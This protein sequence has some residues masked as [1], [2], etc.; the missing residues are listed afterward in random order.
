M[1]LN[2]NVI[3][4]PTCPASDLGGIDLLESTAANLFIAGHV[5]S[6]K[7]TFVRHW[8]A[9]TGETVAVLAPMGIARR[10]RVLAGS[11]RW[12]HPT[13]SATTDRRGVTGPRQHGAGHDDS[14]RA[15]RSGVCKGGSII[16]HDIEFD[17]PFCRTPANA[18]TR[19]A[20][21][22]ASGVEGLSRRLQR[23]TN[24]SG[25]TSCARWG[26]RLKSRRPPGVAD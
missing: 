12:S 20:R 6:G 23:P 22:S 14:A 17:L 8:L 24:S 25:G 9:I 16:D 4:T 18:A 10:F 1:N 19:F 11:A 26:S 21:R 15:W 2:I 7:T 13:A 5:D 3:W